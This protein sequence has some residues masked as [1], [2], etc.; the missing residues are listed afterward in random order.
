MTGHLVLFFTHDVSL[1]TWKDTGLYEREIR[2]YKMLAQAGWKI[3]FMTGGDKTDLEFAADLAPI[4]I[5]P[6][7][8][9]SPKSKIL[10]LLLSPVPVLK[11]HDAISSADIYKTNQF[12]GG[13]NAIIA[14]WL[15]RGRVIARGGYEYLAFA[16]AQKKRGYQIFIAWL[17]DWFLYGLADKIVLATDDDAAFARETFPFLKTRAIDIQPNWID[18]DLFTPHLSSEPFADLVYIGR[19]NVQKN[20]NALIRAT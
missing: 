14:R 12:W 17:V 19:L 7:H 10:R 18:T 9:V 6:A 20:L 2:P 4:Q 16:K 3:S 13:W 1:Q 8:G 5:L 15:Y 11:Q